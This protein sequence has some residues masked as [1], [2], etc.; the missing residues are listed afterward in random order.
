MPGSSKG[1]KQA[2]SQARQTNGS[3]PTFVRCDLS[4]KEKDTVKNGTITD[5]D[6]VAN[7]AKL[8]D[9][10]Y[11]FST[12]PDNYSGGVA[13][14]LTGVGDECPNKGMTLAGRGP[15][16]WDAVKVLLFKHYEILKELWPHQDIRSER[17]MWG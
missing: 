3:L 9:N 13:A 14:F 11:K 4:G 1:S 6:L 5:A 8:V 15:T 2:T 7:I 12:G 10:G 16:L 17:D